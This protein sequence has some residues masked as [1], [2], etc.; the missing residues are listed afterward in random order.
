MDMYGYPHK[1][2]MA[3]DRMRRED[4]GFILKTAGLGPRIMNG[5]GHHF[6]MA[7]GF[8]TSI[9]DGCGCPIMNGRRP[10]LPGATMVTIIAGRRLDPALHS[11]FLTGLQFIAGRFFHTHELSVLIWVIIMYLMP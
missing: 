3:L 1:S 2:P 8:T 4:A 7:T 5:A 6:I 9:M 10:G 11:E